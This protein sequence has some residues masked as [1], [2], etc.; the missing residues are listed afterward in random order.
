MSSPDSMPPKKRQ[1]QAETEKVNKGGKTLQLPLVIGAMSVFHS[2]PASVV[3]TD[4][5][6]LDPCLL[7]KV[8]VSTALPSMLRPVKI[9]W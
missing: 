1:R 2:I 4:G 9:R 6:K 8:F 3:G 7:A 5:L